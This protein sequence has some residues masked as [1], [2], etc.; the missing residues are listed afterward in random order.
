MN[1]TK[2]IELSSRENIEQKPFSTRQIL[3]IKQ[4]SVDALEHNT[5][6]LVG[7]GTKQRSSTQK[8]LLQNRGADSRTDEAKKTRASSADI[9]E[10]KKT[11]ASSADIKNTKKTRTKWRRFPYSLGAWFIC[12]AN[13]CS[14]HIPS[15]AASSALSRC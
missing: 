13:S 1:K 4:N 6:L 12:A 9:N 8:T 2:T 7:A 10:A 11:R 15:G 14:R 3:R 5:L